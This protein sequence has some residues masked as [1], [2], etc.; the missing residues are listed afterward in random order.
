MED[1]IIALIGSGLS[2]VAT[3][4]LLK[5]YKKDFS[6]LEL[7]GIGYWLDIWIALT[8]LIINI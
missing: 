4:I 8:V 5:E 3:L 6:F 1:Q 2:I 7:L